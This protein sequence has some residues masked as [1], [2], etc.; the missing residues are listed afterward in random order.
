LAHLTKTK[1]GAEATSVGCQTSKKKT[2]MLN[3]RHG[4]K[5]GSFE[6]GQSEKTHGTKTTKESDERCVSREGN[7]TTKGKRYLKGKKTGY[8]GSSV[9]IAPG[10]SMAEKRRQIQKKGS[11]GLKVWFIVSK[12]PPDSIATKWSNSSLKWEQ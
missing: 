11:R 2:I 9:W 12:E 7:S 5:S 4:T 1:K 8:V 3:T 10:G 6:R